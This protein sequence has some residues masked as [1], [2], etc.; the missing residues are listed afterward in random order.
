ME[1]VCDNFQMLD[2]KGASAAKPSSP[3]GPAQQPLKKK[4]AKLQ[5]RRVSPIPYT[6]LGKEQ[7]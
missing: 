4:Y 3:S 5:K 2:S 6:V 7:P 1:I